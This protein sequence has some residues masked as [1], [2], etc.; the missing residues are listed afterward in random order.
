MDKIKNEPNVKNKSIFHRVSYLFENINFRTHIL[1]MSL[2]LLLSL[3]FAEK[4]KLII[5]HHDQYGQLSFFEHIAEFLVLVFFVTFL[6]HLI[7]A[8]TDKE[9]ANKWEKF[10]LYTLPVTALIMFF[11]ESKNCTW[12]CLSNR[13]IFLGFSFLVYFPYTIYYITRAWL[14]RFKIYSIY[15]ILI[16]LIVCILIPII[17]LILIND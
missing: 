10:M 3:F 13:T 7:R 9:N 16:S 8:L 4:R 17:I 5:M 11:P 12:W 1:F 15:K 2:F 6:W 14:N